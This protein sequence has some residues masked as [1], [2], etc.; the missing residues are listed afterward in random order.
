MATVYSYIRFSSK[1]QERGDSIRRQVSMGEAWL[2][3]HPEHTLD[4]TL[5]LQDLGK[6]AFRGANLDK[7]K[8]DLGRF[9]HLVRAGKIPQGSI[10]MLEKED[11]FSRMGLSWA[12]PIFCE[13]VH[14]GIRVLVLGPEFI[15]DNSNIDNLAVALP[16]VIKMILANEESLKKS[17]RQ[18][19][20]WTHKRKQAAAG[21][22]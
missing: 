3:R 20:T 11:R 16:V 7:E 18:L 13:L 15:F 1:K 2:K 12:Y 9:I 4:A 8:G 17:Q 6:S 22:P 21:Q 14:A 19:A 5:R 10:L